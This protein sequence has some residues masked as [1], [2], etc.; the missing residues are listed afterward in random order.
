MEEEQ[1]PGPKEYVILNGVW[2]KT[3]M[4]WFVDKEKMNAALPAKPGAIQRYHPGPGQMLTFTVTAAVYE[5]YQCVAHVHHRK[6]AIEEYCRVDEEWKCVRCHD[7]VPDAIQSMIKLYR[8]LK[9][10]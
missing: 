8:P 4:S 1:T 2:Q 10:V 3:D 5:N 9:D 6:T 7:E